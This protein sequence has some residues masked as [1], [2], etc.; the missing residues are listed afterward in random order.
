M[1]AFTYPDGRKVQNGYD[2]AGRFQSVA[3]Q[4]WN[5]NGHSYTYATVPSGSFDAA[6]HVTGM[7]YGNALG[8]AASY[9]NRQRV[10]Y[11]AYGSTQQLLWGRQ[12]AWTSN[13]NL[14][15]TTDMLNGTQRQ[16]GYDSL[17]RLTAAQDIVGSTSGANTS[18]YSTGNGGTTNGSSSGSTTPAASPTWTDPDDSNILYNPDVPGSQ[19]WVMNQV[20]I[21]SG[22]PAPDGSVSAYRVTSTGGDSFIQAGA[23]AQNLL[24][25]ETMIG[26]VWLRS[27]SGPRTINLYMVENSGSG[28]DVPASKT[29]NLTSTWQQYNLSG[30]YHSGQTLILFS[31]GAGGSFIS[32][33]VD[34]WGAKLVDQ[35][36]TGRTVTN[37]LPYSQ[38]LTTARWQRTAV[39]VTDNSGTAPDGTNTAATLTAYPGNSDAALTAVMPNPAL[40]GATVT[41]S[42]WLRAPAQ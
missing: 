10:Q 27:N 18:N 11:L 1:T 31:I 15:Y 7:L 26:S 37:F 30:M 29:V 4:S 41:G 5:G 40:S 12:Y 35:G 42:V 8:L 39:T 2:A 16:F 19:G 36:Q 25:N 17:N 3:Y 33:S 22:F 32:G 28:Y 20:T 23:P 34:M 6:G 9:D 13:S 24:D 21:N 14:N 38:R